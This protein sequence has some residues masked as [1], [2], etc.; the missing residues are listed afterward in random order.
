MPQK[1]MLLKQTYTHFLANKITH[2]FAMIAVILGG[3]TTT[4]QTPTQAGSQT[5]RK[6]SDLQVVVINT[7]LGRIVIELNDLRT[8]LHAQNFRKIIQDGTLNGTMFHRVIPGF[9]IQGGDPNSRD[10]DRSNDGFGGPGYTVPFEGG[11]PARRG[12]VVMARI[13]DE[14]NPGKA[15]NGSQFYILLRDAPELTGVDTVFGRVLIGMDVVERISQ[16]PADNN[17]NPME[18]VAMTA[19][20][21][22]FEK[23]CNLAD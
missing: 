9:I 23:V 8:P 7:R 13:P 17:D 15:S 5:L 11:L 22:P 21:L 4:T 3:C 2:L 18:F 16:V 14:H 10:N 1:N 19:E 12:S 6:P 20:I